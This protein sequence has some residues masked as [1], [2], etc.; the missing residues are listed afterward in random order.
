MNTKRPKNCRDWCRLGRFVC[1]GF[2]DSFELIFLCLRPGDRLAVGRVPF[3]G[4][5]DGFSFLDNG[6]HI[7]L[8]AYHGVQT[9]M[10][11]IGVQPESAFFT[12]AFAMAYP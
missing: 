8:G 12:P 9:L 6:Q 7:L 1:G 3:A 2:S 5:D 10:Q 11:H 4:K